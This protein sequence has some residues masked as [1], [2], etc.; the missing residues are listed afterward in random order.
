MDR[1]RRSAGG[2]RPSM[3]ATD[4]RKTI[5]T[6]DRHPARPAAK[7]AGWI[8]ARWERRDKQGLRLMPGES[9][10]LNPDEMLSQHTRQPMRRQRPRDRSQMLANAR[11]SLR[12]RQQ[13]PDVVRTSFQPRGRARSL[14]GCRWAARVNSWMLPGGMLP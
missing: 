2:R 3:Q 14:R 5:P 11:S 7:V 10:E 13:Q 12:R 8:E 6:I 9:P 4:G 1:L